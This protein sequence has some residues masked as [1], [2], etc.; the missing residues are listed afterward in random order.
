MFLAQ[1]LCRKLVPHPSRSDHSRR[2]EMKSAPSHPVPVAV[3][4]RPKGRCRCRIFIKAIKY[5]TRTMTGETRELQPRL[6]ARINISR[7]RDGNTRSGVWIMKKVRRRGCG[8]RSHAALERSYE[9]KR[10]DASCLDYF[11][12]LATI[13]NFYLSFIFQIQTIF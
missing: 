5:Y 13:S 6:R 3:E 2:R 8:F 10:I 9:I 7:G 4:T 11:S 12:R 1:F